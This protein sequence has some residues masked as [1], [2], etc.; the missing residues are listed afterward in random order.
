TFNITGDHLHTNVTHTDVSCYGDSTGEGYIYPLSGTAPYSYLWS[1]TPPSTGFSVF[2]LTAGSY[3]VTCTDSFGCADTQVVVIAPGTPLGTAFI[4]TVTNATFCGA[5]D[6]TIT[7]GGLVPYSINYAGYEYHGSWTP[8]S[9]VADSNGKFT[10]NYL[11][12]GTYSNI[13]VMTTS[14]CRY[15]AL[16]P[17][18]ISAPPPPRSP[19]AGNSGPVCADSVLYLF[20]NDTETGVSFSWRG[21]GYFSS[22]TQNPTIS[23]VALTDSG[24]YYVWAN[25]RACSTMDS[26]VVVVKP[27]PVLT[28]ADSMMATVGDSISL[29]GADTGFTSYFWWNPGGFSSAAPAPVIYPV[30]MGDEA[31]YYL[32]VNLDG[33]TT[34]DSTYLSVSST[35]RCR[36]PNAFTPNNDGTNDIF[37]PSFISPEVTGYTFTIFN[38]WGQIVFSTTDKTKG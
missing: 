5:R 26:T 7:I 2:H 1:T 13:S 3:S 25:A 22:G 8:T 18:T 14:H 19:V 21:P 28:L 24:V 34:T 16:G 9:G 31:M 30:T 32:T 35:L 23:P 6:G 11:D 33:C 12:T 4:D 36:V 29:Y 37:L 20:A 38:R 27:R 15:N 10:F 17:I